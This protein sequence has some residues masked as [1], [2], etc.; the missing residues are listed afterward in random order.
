MSMLQFDNQLVKAATFEQ[1]APQQEPLAEEV[2]M[3]KT[4]VKAMTVKKPDLAKYRDRYTEGLQQLIDAKVQGKE[5]VAPP[6]EEAPQVINIM[7]ALRKSLEQTGREKGAEA[8][9]TKRMA[10]SVPR[11]AAERKKK[12]S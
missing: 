9:P 12:S 1:D 6:A 11:K 5:I 10:K 8:K 7:E 4:L 3:M 2:A